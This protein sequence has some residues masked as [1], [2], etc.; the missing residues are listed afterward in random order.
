MLRDQLRERGSLQARKLRNLHGTFM[1]VVVFGRFGL[2]Q[3]P[4]SK[5]KFPILWD[6]E[7]NNSAILQMEN[8]QERA[9]I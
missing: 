3:S 6:S 2:M 9:W 7:L 5:I 4:E 8:I 1:K